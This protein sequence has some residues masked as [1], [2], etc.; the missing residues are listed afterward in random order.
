[1]SQKTAVPVIVLPLPIKNKIGPSLANV[2][3]R[4]I[5]SI[6]GYNYSKSFQTIDNDWSY[7][8]LYLFLQKPK[9]WAPGTK[10]VLQRYF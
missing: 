4:K 2:V 10:N 9:T 6:E 5:G 8:N 3:N 1:M 7:E